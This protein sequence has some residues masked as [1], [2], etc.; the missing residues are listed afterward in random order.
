MDEK[1]LLYRT[2]LNT[3]ASPWMP[4]TEY[5]PGATFL[6]LNALRIIT[7]EATPGGISGGGVN[8]D[9][10]YW[11]SPFTQWCLENAEVGSTLR[12]NTIIWKVVGVS[13]MEVPP[14]IPMPERFG[15]SASF[16]SEPFAIGGT[17]VAF[18]NYIDP[19]P[20]EPLIHREWGIFED[21]W[22]DIL[23]YGTQLHAVQIVFNAEIY[24]AGQGTVLIQD[25]I[26]QFARF[27]GPQF[28]HILTEISKIADWVGIIPVTQKNAHFQRPNLVYITN[29]RLPRP[30]QGH[31]GRERGGAYSNL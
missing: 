21:F 23:R 5:A 28:K 18:I 11:G 12:D 2:Q 8:P 29:P 4:Q 22:G 27:Y 24:L 6:S 13:S 19:L 16:Q 25:Y 30:G 17:P 26:P 20:F 9:G 14:R 3:T 31:R 7:F 1:K 15:G 10:T